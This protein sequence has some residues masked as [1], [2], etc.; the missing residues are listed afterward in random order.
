MYLGL[1]HGDI[2][3]DNIVVSADGT[4]KITDFGSATMVR[5]FAVAFTATQTVNF[6]VRWAA[7]ELFRSQCPGPESDVYAYAKTVLVR[8]IEKFYR[9]YSYRTAL[10]AFRKL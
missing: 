9:L 2:K 10:L 5:E 7:P 6:S 4:A 3:G 1:A 8:T